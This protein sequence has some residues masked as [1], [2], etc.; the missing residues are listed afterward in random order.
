MSAPGAQGSPASTTAA[1]SPSDA[2]SPSVLSAARD[3]DPL[4]WETVYRS[5][6]PALLRYASKKGVPHPD[7]VVQDTFAAAAKKMASFSGSPAE[8]RSWLFAIAYCRCADYHRRAYRSPEEL[9]DSLPE[10]L[11]TPS[12]DAEFWASLD[13]EEC[14]AALDILSQ[15]ERDVVLLRVVAG[16][17]TTDVAS[18]L[19]LS[20]ANVRVIQFRALSK[21]RQH[22]ENNGGVLDKRFRL[23]LW[24]PASL[25]AALRR[26]LR[27]AE[28]SRPSDSAAAT[29]GPVPTLPTGT[30][31]LLASLLPTL[32]HSTAVAAFALGAALA[33]PAP[34]S[35]SPVSPPTTTP[36]SA[37]AEAS[38]LP[39][40]AEGS[41]GSHPVSPPPPGVPSEL[42]PPDLVPL[43]IGAPVPTL[44]TTLP[45]PPLDLHPVPVPLPET[46]SPPALENTLSGLFEDLHLLDAP[47][48]PDDLALPE[49][50]DQLLTDVLPLLDPIPESPLLQG[51]GTLVSDLDTPLGETTDALAQPIDDLSELVT[52]LEVLPGELPV[53]LAGPLTPDAAPDPGGLLGRR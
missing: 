38:T 1:R 13:T 40:P 35:L 4:A 11:S 52:E 24:A 12:S 48:A 20:P 37:P 14:L 50:T 23:N 39:S 36:A 49:L 2:V 29:P 33:S 51:T 42:S 53:E 17:P 18:G 5:Y 47:T 34:H 8:F 9:T 7:D 22:L 46:V 19:D 6:A 15:R 43:G 21:L 25:L 44:A 30:S 31:H 10:H 26:R 28:P 32:S 16:I 27:P 45:A 3:D 41:A